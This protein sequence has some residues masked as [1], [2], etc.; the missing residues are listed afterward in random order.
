MKASE[1]SGIIEVRRPKGAVSG[2]VTVREVIE[3][4]LILSEIPG[5]KDE[6]VI[7][8]Q[9]QALGVQLP[10]FLVGRIKAFSTSG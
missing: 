9:R 3:E 10:Y 1:A 5:D 4:T 6:G 8:L 7:C 2:A